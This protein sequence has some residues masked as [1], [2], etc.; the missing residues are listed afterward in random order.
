MLKKVQLIIFDLDGTLIDTMGDF[1]DI[2]GEL[3]NDHYDWVFEIG[4]KRYLETSGIPFFQQLEVLFPRHVNNQK[5]AELFEER[6]INAFLRESVSEKTLETLQRLRDLEIRTAISS[7][8]FQA[9]V[10]EF[11]HRENV[12]IDLA[13]GY[14]DDFCK[15]RPHFDYLQG[16]F[17]IPCSEMLFIGDSLRDATVAFQND[18][19]FVAKLG[20]FTED[21]FKAECNSRFVPII[22]EVHEILYILEGL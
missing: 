11:V 12:A 15:G 2:A 22:Y 1:A 8:N 6:K 3:I 16:Y 5:V 9:L 19:Q 10:K 4:R 20:T 13:L 21:D 17:G 18:I 14:R 7:N